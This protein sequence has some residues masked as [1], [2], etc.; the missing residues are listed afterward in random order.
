MNQRQTLLLYITGAVSVLVIIASVF[1]GLTS[2]SGRGYTGHVNKREREMTEGGYSDEVLK[3]RNILEKDQ[4]NVEAYIQIAEAYYQIGDLDSAIAYLEEGY[5]ITGSSTLYLLKC[6]YEDERDEAASADAVINDELF[7]ILSDYA[8]KDYESKGI[9]VTE[10]SKDEVTADSDY[11]N[12]E[13]CFRNTSTFPTAIKD[14]KVKSG[15]YPCEVSL[16]DPM[17]L[18]GGGTR[19]NFRKL[20]EFGLKD[21]KISEKENYPYAVTFKYKRCSVVIECSETGTVASGA[22]NL[23]IPERSLTQTAEQEESNEESDENFTVSGRISSTEGQR[24]SGVHLRFTRSSNGRVQAETNTGSDGYYSVT[25]PKGSYSVSASADGYNSQSTTVNVANNTTVNM[26]LTPE[27][28]ENE[29]H[30]VSGTITDAQTGSVIASAY[31][32]FTD[33][34]NS[35]T[36]GTART[37]SDGRYSVSVPDGNYTVTITA[38]NYYAS[39]QSVNV[40]GDKSLS[41]QL[42]PIN[43]EPETSTHYI[44]GYVM[45][46]NSLEGISSVSI[47]FNSDFGN[48]E[49]YS[50]TTGSDGYFEVS[51]EDGTYTAVMTCGGYLQHSESVTVDSDIPINFIMTP[52]S[53][54]APEPT[55]DPTP[56]PEPTDEPQ[57]AN[58]TISG[59]VVD[60][61]S[62]N[63][64][65]G[66]TVYMN[67]LTTQSLAATVYTD[68][69]GN[70]S[71]TVPAGEYMVTAECSGYTNDGQYV[72]LNGNASV[73]IALIPSE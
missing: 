3:Y 29:N 57:P 34:S 18:F 64:L 15:V 48:T 24:L 9:T 66:A 43:I 56:A 67:N 54:P 72:S 17:T 25:L 71:A 39:V 49:N 45:D 59:T 61:F 20:Q 41:V 69:N 22:G 13:L 47:T 12:A 44:R 65:A 35:V 4:N 36:R 5:E 2:G 40:T 33:N 55:T 8:Y 27:E 42:T 23:I 19:V 16:K 51:C 26:S 7:G 68:G 50:C 10:S 1:A 11:I 14:E 46:A 62:G 6:D 28:V 31:L 58:Y 32:E 38:D 52:D 37:N 21:L 53:T 70:F 30:T 63:P 73:Y 60:A